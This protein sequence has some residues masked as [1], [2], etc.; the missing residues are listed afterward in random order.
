MRA[1]KNTQKKIV[2]MRLIRDRSEL[3]AQNNPNNNNNN[4]NPN[5]KIE[6]KKK[7]HKNKIINSA[8]DNFYAFTQYTRYYLDYHKRPREKS[9]AHH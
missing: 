9:H 7:R 6:E 8:S 2:M 5:N 1:K 3:F 4:N